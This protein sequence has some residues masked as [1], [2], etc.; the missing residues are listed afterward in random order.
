MPQ[1][2]CGNWF[3]APVF[4]MKPN[5]IMEL[6]QSCI[7]ASTPETYVNSKEWTHGHTTDDTSLY[8]K[9]SVDSY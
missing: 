1:C 8:K 2:S 3:H 7:R 6:C 4:K 5:L 9:E